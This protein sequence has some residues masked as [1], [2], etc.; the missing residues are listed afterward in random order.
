MSQLFPAATVVLFR[1]DHGRGEVFMVSRH[2]RIDTFSGAVVFPGGKVDQ[3]DGKIPTAN[4]GTPLPKNAASNWPQRA[5][6]IA[7][8]REA[9]EECGVLLARQ[10][11]QLLDQDALARLEADREQLR[12]GELDFITLCQTHSL[13]LAFDLLTPFARWIT[14]E[15]RP[16]RFDTWFFLA[17]LPSAQP[18]RHDGYENLDSQWIEP[19]RAITA[20]RDGQLILVFP[21]WMNLAKLSRYSSID[22]ALANAAAAPI[23]TVQPIVE[24]DPDG[25]IMNIPEAADYDGSRFFVSADGR[26]LKRLA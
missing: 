8:I 12:A 4:N 24:P 11:D 18:A 17:P 23:V 10:N 3:S 6:W 22:Q 7:A 25:T 21:T 16:K 26:Q 15:S 1:D 9:Y 2:H 20:A 14:P 19:H 5:F 13:Q